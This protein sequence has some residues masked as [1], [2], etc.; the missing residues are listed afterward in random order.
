MSDLTVAEVRRRAAVIVDTSKMPG[1]DYE[2]L[3]SD[4]DQ[5]YRDVLTAIA[6]GQPYAREMAVAAMITVSATFPRYCA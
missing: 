1:N 2:A 5:L 3:H 6:E 4:E